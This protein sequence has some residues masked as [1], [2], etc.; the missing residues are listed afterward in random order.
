MQPSNV[1]AVAAAPQTFNND[2]LVSL[3]NLPPFLL[4]L[5]KSFRITSVYKSLDPHFYQCSRRTTA[6]EIE[7][8]VKQA[9]KRQMHHQK[10]RIPF[11]CGE[12]IIIT[13][14]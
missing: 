3:S 5:R 13:N 10:H 12:M 9:L 7:A 11:Q 4:L 6:N 2:I 1:M 14:K 8:V